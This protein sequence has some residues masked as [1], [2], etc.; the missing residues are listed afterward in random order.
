MYCG[1]KIHRG[2]ADSRVTTNHR[3]GTRYLKQ[4]AKLLRQR[5]NTLHPDS[6]TI[7]LSVGLLLC[8]YQGRSGPCQRC[9]SVIWSTHK[10][11]D[12]M[13]ATST[14]MVLL[15]YFFIGSLLL[16]SPLVKA[17]VLQQP[18]NVDSLVQGSRFN[19]TLNEPSLAGVLTL[20]PAYNASTLNPLPIRCDSPG[21]R[22]SVSAS[23]CMDA[24][25]KI[26]RD[27]TP[28]LYGQRFL[29]SYDFVLPRRF[30][31]GM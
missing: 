18:Q 8:I 6:I 11:S 12:Q 25:R 31:N 16:Y 23:R 4:L 13:F 3:F 5:K 29:G 7:F 10:A 2:S 15:L 19:L 21:F 28:R 14:L 9:F 27:T 22:P 24:I 1:L 30:L 26:G 17:S 20:P